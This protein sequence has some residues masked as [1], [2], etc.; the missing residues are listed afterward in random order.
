MI[1]S[2][3]DANYLLF[4]W[5]LFELGLLVELGCRFLA[6]LS[7]RRPSPLSILRSELIQLPLSCHLARCSL[8]VRANANQKP[9]RGEKKGENPKIKI[10]ADKRSL[11][12]FPNIVSIASIRH[13]LNRYLFLSIW[14]AVCVRLLLRAAIHHACVY[15]LAVR[16]ASNMRKSGENA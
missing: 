2:P 14:R 6:S 13:R 3:A 16:E 11:I 4:A 9:K 1:T 5:D 12:S 7:L 15:A 8:Y 10:A